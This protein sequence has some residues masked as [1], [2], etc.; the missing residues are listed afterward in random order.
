MKGNFFLIRFCSVLILFVVQ[1]E[2]T[3]QQKGYQAGNKSTSINYICSFVD[4]PQRTVL[5]TLEKRLI[6]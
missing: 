5:V 4:Q 3:R 1:H 6:T 2:G